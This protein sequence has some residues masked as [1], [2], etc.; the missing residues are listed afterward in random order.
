MKK[1]KQSQLKNH[2][3]QEILKQSRIKVLNQ[4][5]KEKT[6]SKS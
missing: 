5:K 4:Y 1:Y 3:C 6:D 2:L